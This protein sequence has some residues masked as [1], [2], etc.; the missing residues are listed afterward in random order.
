MVSAN[1]AQTRADE[2]RARYLAAGTL[3]KPQPH[4]DAAD[5]PDERAEHEASS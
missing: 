4:A 3:G 2:I 1:T 5:H